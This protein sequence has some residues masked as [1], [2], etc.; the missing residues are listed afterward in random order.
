VKVGVLASPE[1]FSAELPQTPEVWVIDCP[2]APDEHHRPKG[3]ARSESI[4][5]GRIA[6]DVFIGAERK[7][8]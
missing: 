3:E 8:H 4:L 1:G 2:A 5:G 6:A 7:D